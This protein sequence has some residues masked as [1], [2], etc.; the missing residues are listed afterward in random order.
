VIYFREPDMNNERT[1]LAVVCN[2]KLL[3]RLKLL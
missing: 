3:R 1:A 2:P